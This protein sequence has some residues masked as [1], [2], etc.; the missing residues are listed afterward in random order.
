MRDFGLLQIYTGDGKGKTTA[1]LGLAFRAAG[2][3]ARVRVFQFMKPPQSS[4]EHFSSPRLAPEMEI[5]PLGKK[6]WVFNG[7]PSEEDIGMAYDG[8]ET[9]RAALHSDQVDL[10]V[11]DEL[12]VTVLLNLI[13]LEDVLDLIDNRP[14]EVE[15]V[16]TGRGAGPELMDRADLVTEMKAVKHPFSAGIEARKGIEF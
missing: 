16:I 3:G 12:L 2:R 1:A 9:F 7:Q 5:I 15:L 13:R 6:G 14:P 4:G 11:A 8:L 10:V